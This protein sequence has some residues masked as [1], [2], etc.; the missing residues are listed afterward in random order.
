MTSSWNLNLPAD[1]FGQYT[2]GIDLN[3]YKF[4]G[5]GTDF[6]AFNTDIPAGT[7]G[8]FPALDGSAAGSAAFGGA[9]P[10]AG[11]LGSWGGM[12]ALGGIANT[13]LNQVGNA[14]GT[15]AGQAYLDFMADKRDADFGSAFLERNAD[16][17]DQFKVA[18]LID[19]Y[20]ANDPNRRQANRAAN[21]S[22]LA[23]KYGQLGGFLA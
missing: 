20:R 22:D 13:V 2:T 19:K 3:K 7:F 8:S 10:G 11:G 9:T 23:G 14:Q 6:P 17:A 12:Q 18:R 1:A 4:P 16:I 5:P 15:Q 21:L